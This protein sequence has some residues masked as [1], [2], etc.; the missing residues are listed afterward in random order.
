MLSGIY[1]PNT[2]GPARFAHAFTHHF[3]QLGV[4]CSVITYTDIESSDQEFDGVQVAQISRKFSLPKRY[5]LLIR[6]IRQEAQSGSRFI[7]NGCFLEIL[8]ASFTT[9]L[10]FVTKVPGDIVW[11]RARNSNRTQ[12]NVD[13]FQKSKLSIGLKLFR[14]LFS[15]SLIK[16]SLVIV[17]SAH[18]FEL[19]LGW[20]VPQDRIILIQNSV[21]ISTFSPRPSVIKKFDVV[22]VNRLV[23][24]KGTEAVIKACAKLNLKLLVIGDGPESA[25]LKKTAMEH[26]NKVSFHGEAQ[27]D[28]IVGLLNSASVFVLNS[29]FEATSYALLEARSCGLAS[30]ARE[31][32][33]SE[34]IIRHMEDGIL[35]GPKSGMQLET[36]LETLFSP[37]F[38]L[39]KMGDR[40][41]LDVE[42]RFNSDFNFRKILDACG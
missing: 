7:A 41:R 3:S 39:A 18:L 35:C 22:V 37:E 28:E 8:L 11:E 19:C 36:A 33:G 13:D 17:P 9:R 32:T 23:S 24:W 26:G 27:H 16:S 40:A 14:F 20:G 1:P 29:N 2:G 12:L 25:A 31:S 10:K 21:S 6:R 5:L 15:Q 34:E 4:P 38:P 30:I 42:T